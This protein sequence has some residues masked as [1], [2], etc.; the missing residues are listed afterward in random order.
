MRN[1]LLAAAM[2][3]AAFCNSCGEEGLESTTNN[4]TFDGYIQKGPFIVGT[5]VDLIELDNSLNPTGKRFST[6][7]NSNFGDFNIIFKSDQPYAEFV[8]DGSY[9]DEVKG[10]YSDERLTLRAISKMDQSTNIN[11]LTTIQAGRMRSLIKDGKGFDD[12]LTQSKREVLSIFNINEEEVASFNNMNITEQ[13]ISNSI[14][15]AISSTLQ[16]GRTTVE[17]SE[18]ISMLSLDLAED[19]VVD[20]KSL[21][22]KIVESAKEVNSAEVIHNLEE[23]YKVLGEEVT[24]DNFYDFIDSDGDGVLNGGNP[25]LS[26]D[27]SSYTFD[28]GASREAIYF[29]ANYT[30]EVKIV[31]DD[32]F[33]SVASVE[34]S[35]V[36]LDLSENKGLTKRTAEL[37][38]LSADGEIVESVFI[39]Q[40]SSYTEVA[41]NIRFGITSR[42]TR[43]NNDIDIERIT[44]IA[45]DD[46]GNVLFND[47]NTA[48]ELDG[49]RYAL[50]F[51]FVDRYYK[52]CTVY[53][54]VNGSDDYSAITEIADV[55]QL[56]S[57]ISDSVVLS[58]K[59]EKV[60]FSSGRPADDEDGCVYVFPETDVILQYTGLSRV[61]FDVAFDESIAASDRVVSSLNINGDIYTNTFLFK[62]LT[63][64]LVPSMAVNTES[65]SRLVG[66]GSNIR[67]IDITLKNGTHYAITLPSDIVLGQGRAYQYK[68]TIS[69]KGATNSSTNIND[70]DT[71]SGD[72]DITFTP[73]TGSTTR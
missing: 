16:Q 9:F 26:I 42:S 10:D 20:D 73:N 51:K 52:D 7:I 38:L 53:T 71:S 23:R 17:M 60:G 22:D 63:G 43:A 49:N 11:I 29:N 6:Q 48:P 28:Y 13:G 47:N 15:L 3:A 55:E 33:I 35:K 67:G 24:I 45:F 58:A 18:L 62:E 4:F 61:E 46:D 59:S 66:S 34:G 70:W 8:A 31:G 40:A 54:I 2:I 68:I 21:N 50:Y 1:N 32:N 12:A 25:H 57:E 41:F 44:I 36:V 27:K 37:Q 19:G 39:E 14:L 30:P 64:G 56:K 65:L 69:A 5:S 72:T